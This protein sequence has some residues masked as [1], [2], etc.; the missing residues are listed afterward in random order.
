M[1]NLKTL[2]LLLSAVAMGLLTVLPL[3]SCGDEE[4]EMT[5]GGNG[6]NG[7]GSQQSARALA[8]TIDEGA[9]TYEDIEIS[10]SGQEVT[11]RNVPFG[12]VTVTI[13]D[14]PNSVAELEKLK[15][16][17][18]MSN[19]H[20]SPYLQPMLLMCALNEMNYDK[21]EARNMIDY[22]L[23]VTRSE[24]R[25]ARMVHY[26]SETEKVTELYESEWFQVNQYK[27]FDKVR[28]Y[29]NGTSYA[30]NYTPTEKPYS[31]TIEL[32]N[33]SYGLDVDNVKLWLTSTQLSSSR[34]M[35]V[36]KYDADGDGTF[37]TF[38]SESFQWMLHS[39]GEY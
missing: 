29:L 24:N 26:P 33:N 23:R 13:E 16:P 32:K 14:L 4:E 7:G 20:Q 31:M 15:L 6:G 38:W 8:V 11:Q 34:S 35:S 10:G 17:N 27:K 36:M 12:K 18:G 1:K 39:L 25:D 19:I 28:S 5:N 3:T 21:N 30:N 22:V 9:L 37:D 2:G